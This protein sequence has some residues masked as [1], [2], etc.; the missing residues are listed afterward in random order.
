MGSILN[1]IQTEDGAIVRRP[2]A[3]KTAV[4]PPSW[5]ARLIADGEVVITQR[6]IVNSADYAGWFMYAIEA[7]WTPPKSGRAHRSWFLTTFDVLPILAALEANAQR[8]RDAIT[9]GTTR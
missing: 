1:A 4:H 3:R 2:Y 6:V 7:V 9:G 8:S 5:T